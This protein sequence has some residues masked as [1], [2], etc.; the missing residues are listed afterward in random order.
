MTNRCTSRRGVRPEAGEA[1][2]DVSYRS[3][4]SRRHSTICVAGSSLLPT[5]LVRRY[6]MTPNERRW[7]LYIALILSRDQ[8]LIEPFSLLSPLPSPASPAL[9]RSL[10]ASG[11]SPSL[12]PIALKKLTIQTHS[13]N[14]R[15]RL[16]SESFCPNTPSTRLLYE[17]QQP[18]PT[19]S[20]LICPS[21]L[22]LRW[23]KSKSNSR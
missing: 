15:G 2:E 20:R 1:G 10:P 6:Y 9:S 23:S 14:P 22:L 19:I 11:R 12:A 16:T 18:C 7:T 8:T 17:N 4:R 21:R 13:I 3:L 5:T